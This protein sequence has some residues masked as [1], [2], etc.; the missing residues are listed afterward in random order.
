MPGC[1]K[2]HETYWPMFGIYFYFFHVHDIHC[3]LHNPLFKHPNIQVSNPWP[4][5]LFYAARRH[6]C[7]LCLQYKTDTIMGVDLCHKKAGHPCPNGN[8]WR[9]QIMKS[10]VM[11]FDPLTPSTWWTWGWVDPRS[12][13]DAAEKE[14]MS[15]P[16]KNQAQTTVT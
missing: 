1:T 14:K 4:N 15:A 11:H 12:S 8:W 5:M 10:Q 6:V 13:L 3:P 9:V 7:K 2:I 16:A